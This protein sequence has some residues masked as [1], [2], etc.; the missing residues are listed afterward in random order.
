M[1]TA[2]TPHPHRRRHAPVS[3]DGFG[4]VAL[5]L[6]GG[7]ALGSYQA[8][9]FEGLHEASITP[10]W[11]AG[12]SIGALNCALIAGNAPAHRLERLRT[13]WETICRPAYP[14]FGLDWLQEQTL[15]LAPQS[16]R[17]FSAMGAWRAVLEGQMGFFSPRGPWPWLGGDQ[18]TL[19]ASFYDTGALKSTLERLVDFD[20]I[21][22]GEMRVSV[23]AVNV[24]TGNLT[25][26]DNLEGPTRGRLRAEHFMASG[27][28]PP[29]FPAIEIDGEH[30]WDGGLVSNTPLSYVLHHQSRLHTLA[31][32]VDLWSARG[33]PPRNVYEVQERMKDIQ[34]SS[35]T[36]AITEA[37]ANAHQAK[38]LLHEVLEALP[39]DLRQRLAA[40]AQ[41]ESLACQH[42]VSVVHLIYQRKEWE[43]Q[44]KDYEFSPRTMHEHWSSGLDDIEQA[45]SHDDWLQV[46]AHEAFVT[47]DRWRTHAPEPAP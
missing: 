39:A 12:I 15:R 7:G 36:R 47:H 33:Q 9:V 44:A 45:L 26:F 1:S 5:V 20:R 29:A 31:F 21:N 14:V 41:A 22:A 10:N 37:Q 46:S 42:R 6:Q 8:G 17:Y 4:S 25:Y 43:S 23:G 24:R 11:V 40:A 3:T 16:R 19:Q 32:Q 28:L 30:Y 35:R 13:F 34:Y 27:A 2:S 38:S 18:G